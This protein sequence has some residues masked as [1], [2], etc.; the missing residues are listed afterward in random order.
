MKNQ[1]YK[2]AKDFV[3]VYPTPP[4]GHGRPTHQVTNMP[5]EL[6]DQN[7][8]LGDEVLVGSCD[9]EEIEWARPRA[10]NL[11]AITGSRRCRELARIANELKPVL[12]THDRIGRR[13]DFVEFHPAY[14]ELTAE[15]YRSE[16]HS[17]A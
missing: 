3:S 7:L 8:F 17:L 2:P 6:P 13:I 1:T 5:P 9:R 15:I 11:G 10:E 4:S 16:V 14:H 12:R